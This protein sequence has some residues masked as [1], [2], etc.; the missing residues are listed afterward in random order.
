MMN[1]AEMVHLRHA[2]CMP[3]KHYT[4]HDDRRGGAATCAAC[5]TCRRSRILRFGRK[6][7]TCPKN[8]WPDTSGVTT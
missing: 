7:M 3:C 1:L 2:V 6:D 8:L 5:R 4:E